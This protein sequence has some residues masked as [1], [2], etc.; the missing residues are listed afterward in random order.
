MPSQIGEPYVVSIPA[1]STRSLTA[2]GVPSR[3]TSQTVRRA[4][5]SPLRASMRAS[6]SDVV[7]ASA[8]SAVRLLTIGC[9]SFFA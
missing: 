1:V 4:L 3:A 7:G 5:S 6:A 8:C 2:N 9:P